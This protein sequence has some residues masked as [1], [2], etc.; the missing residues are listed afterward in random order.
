VLR[1]LFYLLTTVI[2]ITAVKSVIGIFAKLFSNVA[3]QP[4]PPGQTEGRQTSPSPQ[5]LKKDPV[6]G[7]FVADSTEFQKTK[8]GSTYYFCSAGCRDKF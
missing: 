2:L 3:P 4:R 5:M 6:C 1:A 7:T 8:G